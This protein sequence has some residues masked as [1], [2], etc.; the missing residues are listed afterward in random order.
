MPG[1]AAT[2]SVG[3]VTTGGAAVTNVGTSAAAIFNF[4]IPQG[5]QGNPGASGGN[6]SNGSAATIAVG[7]VTTG[8][9]GSGVTVTNAGTTSAAVFNFAIPRGDVGATGSTGSAG[10]TGGV[11]ATGAQ[12]NPGAT[13]TSGSN[14]SNGAAATIA[15]GTVTT[16]SAGSSASITNGGSTSAAVFNFTIPRGDVGATGPAGPTTVG[17]ANSR[18]LA[19][20]TALQATDNTKPAVF[21]ITLTSTASFSLSGGTTNNA[22]VVIG[23]TSGIGTSGGQTLGKYSN[24]ITG[25]IAVGLNMNSVMTNTYTVHIPTG[26]WV[27]V[28]LT[29]GTVTAS[30]AWDQSLG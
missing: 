23:T 12:G 2:I 14:G 26:G 25:T 9:P 22:D 11:G 21:T 24:S 13:G 4:T 19:L 6:G 3:S 1:N 8:A 10:A 7:T 15:V 16:G 28:R 29:S 20:G 5:E 17:T 30:L 27:A 18:T